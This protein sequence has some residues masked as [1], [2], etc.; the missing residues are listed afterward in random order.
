MGRDWGLGRLGGE[1]TKKGDIPWPLLSSSLS[2]DFSP[3]PLFS[4]Y[5]PS[6][7]AL[8]RLTGSYQPE[9]K[10]TETFPVSSRSGLAYQR[11][12]SQIFSHLAFSSF[13]WF[14]F[15]HFFPVRF[16]FLLYPLHCCVACGVSSDLCLI[17][18]EAGHG[19]A[20]SSVARR[21]PG[22]LRWFV[23]LR[24]VLTSVCYAAPASFAQKP[25][26]LFS[27]RLNAR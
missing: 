4:L 8:T 24:P 17:V 6:P 27:N 22:A 25:S 21:P 16:V 2:L 23:H 7:T 15:F 14:P 3:P 10:G 5:L 11:I 19:A 9:Q 18:H 13:F 1:W 26:F 20:I 12:S